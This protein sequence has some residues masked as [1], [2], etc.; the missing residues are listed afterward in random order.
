V[1][2]RNG[3]KM[4]NGTVLPHGTQTVIPME[5]IHYDESNYASAASYNAFRFCEEAAHDGTKPKSGVTLDESFVSFGYGKHACPGRF[6][7]LH[8]MK[9]MLT[10]LVAHYD[11]QPLKERPIQYN[12]M[13]L[14]LPSEKA[15]IRVRR[16]ARR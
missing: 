16:R 1:S 12:L 5:Q 15:T 2:A 3:L 6:F 11:V 8:E 13:W 9:L 14:K 7:A 4:P 10:H